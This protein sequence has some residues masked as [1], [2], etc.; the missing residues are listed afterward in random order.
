MLSVV[1]VL[2]LIMGILN[3]ANYIN[4]D[5]EA[6]ALLG[7]LSEN[8]G[9][10]PDDFQQNRQLM[11]EQRRAEFSDGERPVPPEGE[12]VSAPEG[13][14]PPLPEGTEG[15]VP[16]EPR[17]DMQL[18]YDKRREFM[19]AETPFETRFFTVT[20][21]ESG[22][23]T[24]CDVQMI[25][26]VSEEKAGEM[27]RA[28]FL[29]GKTSGYD[30]T[31]KY[32]V[33]QTDGGSMYIFLD[34]SRALRSAQNF[35]YMSL[36]VAGSA[37]VLIFILVFIFSGTA[38]KPMAESYEKQKKFITN[39][40]H[41]IKTPLAVINSCVEVI[42]ME[43]GENKWTQGIH[44]QTERLAALTKSLVE[45]ARMDEGGTHLKMEEFSL[46]ETMTEVLEPF[47]MMAEHKG[48]SFETDIQENVCIKGDM[49]SL[50]QLCS[51]MADNAVKYTPENGSIFFSLSAKGR[52]IHM[53]SENTAEGMEKGEHKEL[54]DRF[55]RG[56]ASHNSDKPGYGIGMSMLQAIAEAHGARAEAFSKDGKTLTV[57]VKW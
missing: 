22:E 57:S 41:E 36:L 10:F 7:I 53:Y 49:A 4:T 24:A 54:F 39:A 52:R 33:I 20:L 21:D 48:L 55:H 27:A 14:K 37:A 26:A 2:I 40:G 1:T 11:G 17:S 34:R 9:K 5:N 15:E 50:A 45:L 30:G 19:T 18:R 44:S 13:E 23:V 12:A 38:I 8:G 56:D 43:S 47:A 32:R 46:S 28:L 42:E 3:A 31:Y 6:A 29:A 16:P 25:A 51:I 35:L